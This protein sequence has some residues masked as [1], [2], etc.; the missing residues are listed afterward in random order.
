MVAI[1]TY[2]AASIGRG[3]RM[4]RL[5][6]A[7]LESRFSSLMVTLILS[8]DS[9]VRLPLGS[10]LDHVIIGTVTPSATQ[11]NTAGLGDTTVVS[12]GGTM[13]A[14][15]TRARRKVGADTEKWFKIVAHELILVCNFST[16]SILPNTDLYIVVHWVGHMGR[17]KRTHPP[18][19]PPL[20]TSRTTVKVEEDGRE[21]LSGSERVNLVFSVFAFLK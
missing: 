17:T 16:S 12:M 1:Q 19:Y 11:M 20:I 5:L 18:P 2:S 4:V 13:M 15:G 6:R 8:E 10:S 21:K 14:T 7:V 9:C 3:W